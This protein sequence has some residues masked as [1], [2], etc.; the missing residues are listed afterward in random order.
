MNKKKRII[1]VS[2][3]AVAILMFTSLTSVV[4]LQST[5]LSSMNPSP[6]FGI[7][8]QKE[9]NPEYESIITVDYL[10]KGIT[11]LQI[12]RFPTETYKGKIMVDYIV[13]LQINEL[14][15]FSN[16]IFNKLIQQGMNKLTISQVKQGLTL[17]K[18]NPDCY[19]TLLYSKTQDNA[20][21]T[22][23]CPPSLIDVC[24]STIN[25][26]SPGC[27]LAHILVAILKIIYII[28][29]PTTEAIPTCFS[30]GPHIY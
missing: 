14:M 24:T 8:T 26:W 23:S 17:I 16:L 28:I 29:F 19:K 5:K 2:I 12:P 7:R 10:G 30:C 18:N 6:L 11:S 20:H 27:L 1:F 9:I 21:V 13:Q 4:S 22:R 25:L 15:T 3:G